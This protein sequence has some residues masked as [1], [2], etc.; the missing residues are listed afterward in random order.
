VFSTAALG[1]T[2]H[3]DHSNGSAFLEE[4]LYFKLLCPQ[5]MTGIII[6]KGGSNMTQLNSL[7][8]AKIK[9]SQNGEFF[10]TTNDRVL[11]CKFFISSV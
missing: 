9:L 8:S 5:A 4:N 2:S 11:M 7:T 10:P 3:A 1:I 6:G